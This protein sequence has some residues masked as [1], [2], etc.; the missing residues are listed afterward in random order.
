MQI[1]RTGTGGKFF[2]QARIAKHLGNF[3]EN[4]QVFL[5]RCL[6]H[7]QE[8]QQTNRLLIRRIKADRV[9]QLEYRCHRRLQALDASM[10]NRNAMAKARRAQT[11]PG[12]QAVGNQ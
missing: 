7:Q 2:T 10:G 6:G 11:L 4:F 9:C 1:R 3:R 5:G 8:N 12:K